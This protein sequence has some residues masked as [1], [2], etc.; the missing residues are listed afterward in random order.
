MQDKDIR[1]LERNVFVN[2]IEKIRKDNHGS[3]FILIVDT[4]TLPAISS[5]INTTELI[6]HDIILTELYEKSREPFPMYQAIY[7]LHP[8]VDIKPFIADFEKTPK[9]AAAHLLFTYTCLPS[10][11]NTLQS[12][13][14]VVNHILTFLDLWI[15]YRPTQPGVFMV[16]SPMAFKYLYAPTSPVSE[17]QITDEINYGLIS[18]FLT[19]KAIPSVVYPKSNERMKRFANKLID[20]LQGVARDLDDGG[21]SLNKDNTLLIVFPRGADQIT[22]LLHRFTYQSMI[23]ENF[24]VDNDTVQLKEDD[25]NSVVALNPYEDEIF[26]EYC[27]KHFQ[28]FVEIRNL[29]TEISAV[30]KIIRDPSIDKT[31]SKYADAMKKYI[32]DQAKATTVSNHLEICLRLDEALTKRSLADIAQYE[33]CLAAKEKDGEKYKPNLSELQ[34]IIIKQGPDSIDKLRCLAIYQLAGGKLSDSELERL[35]DAGNLKTGNWK[36]AI[37]NMSYLGEQAP[38]QSL[39]EIN[40]VE[41]P[42]VTDIFYPYAAQTVVDALDNKLDKK[43]WEIPQHSSRYTNVVIFFFGGVSF[44][45]LEKIELIRNRFKSAKIYVGATNTITP[46]SFLVQ[47]RSLQQN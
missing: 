4:D 18:I 12:H 30:H 8:C 40:P 34:D 13:P 31:S 32:R 20:Q 46:R 29:S 43:Y 1:Q 7:L 41:E 25:P 22:P 2:T 38:R 9:Y 42:F 21:K 3:K 44:A 45:E 28:Q 47:T 6:S 10:T 17:N 11:M 24:T 27:Y 14:E 5:L 19:L 33:Q 15:H 16:P 36:D 35:L 37:K 23:Y 26:K 39:R